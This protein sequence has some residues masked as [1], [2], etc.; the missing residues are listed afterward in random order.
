MWCDDKNNAIKVVLAVF[1][2]FSLSSQHI[3]LNVIFIKAINSAKRQ[4]TTGFSNTD[5]KTSSS[6]G[7]NQELFFFLSNLIPWK[8]SY[9]LQKKTCFNSNFILQDNRSVLGTCWFLSRINV[10]SLHWHYCRD[11]ALLQSH[12]DQ[13]Q[14]SE[15]SRG[16][17][18]SGRRWQLKGQLKEKRSRA[19]LHCCSAEEQTERQGWRTPPWGLHW[20]KNI[21]HTSLRRGSK[22]ESSISTWT[23]IQRKGR[24]T[25]ITVSLP[26]GRLCNAMLQLCEPRFLNCR[27][28]QIP[29]LYFECFIISWLAKVHMSFKSGN[30]VLKGC[31]KSWKFD[32]SS[33]K[34]HGHVFEFCQW[35][36]VGKKSFKSYI[37]KS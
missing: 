5:W 1:F 30:S 19:W 20:G 26:L 17:C 33:W 28:T 15:H 29:S 9:T 16:S 18:E 2:V 27:P 24:Q 14:G 25:M 21:P 4:F 3:Y 36:W 34:N 35:K 32:A 13:S 12:V 31:G 8:L 23:R 11:E 37:K 7:L 6:I 22:H 10:L